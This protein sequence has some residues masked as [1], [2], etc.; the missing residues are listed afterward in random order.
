MATTT[1]FVSLFLP[2]K[3]PFSDF[4]QKN[5]PDSH[6][7][8]AG[9][10]FASQISPLLNYNLAKNEKEISF[11]HFTVSLAKIFFDYFNHTFLFTVKS[12]GNRHLQ[13]HST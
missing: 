8:Q 9:M 13:S 1:V 12:K 7:S 5:Y 2:Q 10:K 11:E 6:H 4:E 3:Q